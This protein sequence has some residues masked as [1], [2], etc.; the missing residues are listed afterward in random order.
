MSGFMPKPSFRHAACRLRRTNLFP[1]RLS[2]GFHADTTNCKLVIVPEFTCFQLGKDTTIYGLA[3][4]K[5]YPVPAGMPPGFSPGFVL[6]HTASHPIGVDSLPHTHPSRAVAVCLHPYRQARD[7]SNT[8]ERQ[9]VSPI[10]RG[11]TKNRPSA[12]L[13]KA[14][15]TTSRFPCRIILSDTIH[16][17][18]PNA[19]LDHPRVSK[20]R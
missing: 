14:G 20:C 12:D 2:K 1:R 3:A 13:H 6:P 19:R 9:N 16:P 17:L 11:E 10:I 5:P 15:L 7:K 8:D 18:F 4:A